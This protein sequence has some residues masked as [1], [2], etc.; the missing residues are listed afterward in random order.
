MLNDISQPASS[1]PGQCQKPL[2]M[3]FIFGLKILSLYNS[4]CVSDPKLYFR[5]VKYLN[6]LLCTII[7][8]QISNRNLFTLLFN[9]LSKIFSGRGLSLSQPHTGYTGRGWGGTGSRPAMSF[10]PWK[11]SQQRSKLFPN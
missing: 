5:L 6:V 7:N 2:T 4:Y 9:K 1:H 10:K 11:C 3:N 8:M